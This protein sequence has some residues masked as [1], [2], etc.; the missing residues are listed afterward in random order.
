MLVALSLALIASTVKAEEFEDYQTLKD[1]VNT[2]GDLVVIDTYQRLNPS[3]Y[4]IVDKKTKTLYVLDEKG[5]RLATE[6]IKTYSSDEL[7]KGGAGI[8]TFA[9]QKDGVYYGA[10]EKDKSVHGLFKGNGPLTKGMPM[11]VV[12]ETTSH[13]FRIRNHRITFNSRD[14]LK[15]RPDYN[16]SP[17]NYEVRQSKFT[18]DRTD[19]FTERYVRSL[20]DEKPRLM[21]IYKLEND[22][23]NMLAEFAYGVLAPETKFGSSFKYRLKELFPY[24]P[25][26]LKGNGF[27]TSD[28]SRGPTQIK[29]I[30]ELIIKNYNIEK[31]QLKIP[32]NAAIATLGKAAEL[33]IEIRNRASQHPGISEETL[34]NYMYYLYN[35]LH[36]EIIN[37]SATPNFN[38]RTKLIREAIKDLHIEE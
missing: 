38:V 33:L 29:D 8:Y 26:V 32:E 36:R 9:G 23:Y 27:D 35:G 19:S 31:H 3:P 17:R 30:P 18:V 34:Q 20:Q 15:N 2:Q 16:Y 6:K 21:E 13:R 14:V 11:Y 28:N 22:E 5:N 10:A 37:K 24:V 1:F 4:A 12:P 25:S 7:A